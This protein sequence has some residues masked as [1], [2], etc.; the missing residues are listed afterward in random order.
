MSTPNL[1]Q[2][3]RG[4]LIDPADR[5]ALVQ[6]DYPATNWI[7]WV[8]PGGG[9]EPGEDPVAALRRELI[10]ETGASQ[11]T[12]FIGPV[13][14]HRCHHKPDLIAGYDGQEETVYLVPCHRFELAPAFTP[15]ELAAEHIA[16]VRWWTLD[17]LR[18]TAEIVRPEGLSQLVESVLEHGAPVDPPYF[19][20]TE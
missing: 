11:E 1:R 10:E 5:I 15:E 6:L 18:A 14:W 9:I 12:A 19:E 7:G 16:Q 8:L 13:L 2:A 20:T 17:E 3:V 4:L